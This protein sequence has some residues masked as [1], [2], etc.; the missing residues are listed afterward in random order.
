MYKINFLSQLKAP[1][2]LHGCILRDLLL[3]FKGY[4]LEAVRNIHKTISW[5]LD[6]KFN[7]DCDKR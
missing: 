1:P 4:A 3:Y 2:I 6:Y 7:I 5:S